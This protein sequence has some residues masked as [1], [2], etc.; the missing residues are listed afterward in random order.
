MGRLLREHP[1]PVSQVRGSAAGLPQIKR[2]TPRL[3]IDSLMRGADLAMAGSA[4]AYVIEGTTW[5]TTNTTATNSIAGAS[6]TRI[7]SSDSAC[8]FLNTTVPGMTSSASCLVCVQVEFSIASW[9]TNN[10]SIQ[11]RLCAADAETNTAEDV[12]VTLRKT[13]TTTF[14]PK[15]GYYSGSSFPLVFCDDP[16]PYTSSTPTRAV[17][18]LT[19]HGNTWVGT[20]GDEAGRPD[21]NG[22]TAKNTGTGRICSRASGTVEAAQPALLSNL[23]IAVCPNGGALDVTIEGVRVWRLGP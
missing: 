4:A 16:N 1:G 10:S 17:L 7:N 23:K 8:Y 21:F 20:V 12:V 14:R 6:G 9:V 5:T 18:Q 11:V 13:G 22:L 2:G 3:V 15:L 19:G